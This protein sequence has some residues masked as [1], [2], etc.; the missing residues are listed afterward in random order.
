MISSGVH[1]PS[2][3][4]RSITAWQLRL[5]PQVLALRRDNESPW[6]GHPRE[7]S[8]DRLDLREVGH[9]PHTDDCVDGVVLEGKSLLEVCG[10]ERVVGSGLLSH[11]QRRRRD[12]EPEDL[13]REPSCAKR[14]ADQ[15]GAAPYVERRARRGVPGDDRLRHHR[16]SLVGP[17]GQV[18]VVRLR[19]LVVPV[20]D[21]TGI[22][23]ALVQPV[24]DGVS[25]GHRQT[26]SPAR[27]A[28]AAR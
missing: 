27:S 16:G 22:A 11:L 25:V 5:L 2:S 19:P 15:S 20:G 10:L 17:R 28:K 7:L 1:E 13:S 23:R 18:V 26:S 9:H 14:P 3:R 4:N 8:P 6:P 21:L 12:V 24:G